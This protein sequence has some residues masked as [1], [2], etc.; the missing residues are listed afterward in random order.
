MSKAGD[1]KPLGWMPALRTS[2]EVSGRPGLKSECWFWSGP[3][4]G[5]RSYEEA[6]KEGTV[7]ELPEKAILRA[8]SSC[9]I[10]KCGLHDGKQCTCE[11]NLELW[12]YGVLCW[13][14]NGM[15][16]LP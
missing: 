8:A 5:A 7:D 6:L 2:S 1:I 9:V 11:P 10:A 14:N 4:L 15:K 12:W 13:V 3:L 16:P